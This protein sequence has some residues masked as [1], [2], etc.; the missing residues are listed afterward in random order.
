MS[1]FNVADIHIELGIVNSYRPQD[2]S[3]L[4]PRPSTPFAVD[5]C[6]PGGVKP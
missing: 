1:L 2:I 4:T 3:G 6:R 5:I